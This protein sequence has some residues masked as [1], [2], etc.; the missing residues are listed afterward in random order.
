MKFTKSTIIFQATLF[1][2]LSDAHLYAQEDTTK[3]QQL[4]SVEVKPLG[5][6]FSI[7]R[8]QEV[9]GTII[10]ASKKNEV[11]KIQDLGAD[12][13][14]NNS[15]QLFAKVP[16]INIWESDGSGIQTSIASRGLSPNRSWEFNMRQNG[17][18]ISAEAFG[19]PEAYY[20]PASEGVEQIEIVR[21]AGSLQ[22]GSQMGGMVNYIMKD[23]IQGKPFGFESRQTFGSY[24]LFNTYN[25]IGGETKKIAYYAYVHHRNADGWRKN[26]AYSALSAFASIKWKLHERFSMGLQYTYSTFMSQQPGGLT[27]SLFAL[28]AQQSMRSRNWLSVPWHMLHF[29]ANYQITKG[30]KADLRVFTTIAQRNSIGFTK[31]INVA[32]TINELI[33][34]YNP[35]QIDRD[36]YNNYGA[37]LRLAQQYKL[38]GMSHTL[39][40]GVRI[41]KGVTGR[42]QKGIGSTGLDYD[43]TIAQL[44]N[45][46]EFEKEFTFETNNVAVF[47]ENLFK[48]GKKINLVPGVRYE[49]IN[50]MVDGRK[51]PTASPIALPAVNRNVLLIGVGAEYKLTETINA[52]ANYSN[53]FRPVT[54]SQLTPSATTDVIDP[55]LKD[56]N[57]YSIDG[58]VRGRYK[59]IVNFDVSYFRLTYNDRVGTIKRDNVNFVTNIG[60]SV[61]QGIESFVE[62]D[63]FALFQLEKKAGSLK[64][65]GSYGYTQA[66][67]TKWN[68]PAIVDDPEKSIEGKRVEYAP[69]HTL[70]AGLSYACSYFSIHFQ[71]SYVDAVFTNAEN[72]IEANATATTGVLPAYMVHD[73]TASFRITQHYALK[74]GINNLTNE[75]YATRRSGGYPGPGLLP[76]NGRTFFVTAS[77]QF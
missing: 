46:N 16:G 71:T 52:Y 77:I 53:G 72:T 40:G 38:F 12:L 70:R 26:S 45:G 32:D 69:E 7:D 47:A 9:D 76:A 10:F 64:L 35:R 75:M 29:S 54:Y 56:A 24:G 74:A 2:G 58:G 18:D 28:D 11:I 48:I 34:S 36:G 27:D 43:M 57:G 21:G 61:S 14:I 20:T 30:L 37:E 68:N 65:F 15:R 59:N 67:Y 50:S 55:D 6:E 51:S 8:K 66:L 1:I 25:A 73:L 5:Y 22:Y 49:Q 3:T 13:S 41:Y 63:L 31:A 42:K 62:C 33:G 60:N 4:P 23:R 17:C 39:T 44:N 19:Y